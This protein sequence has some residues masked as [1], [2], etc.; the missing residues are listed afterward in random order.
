MVV[1]L[2]VIS[3]CLAV[4]WSAIGATNVLGVQLSLMKAAIDG[5]VIRDVSAGSAFAERLSFK[6]GAAATVA[7]KSPLNAISAIN[8]SIICLMESFFSFRYP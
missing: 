2:R 1:L 8:A 6:T 3:C 4:A 5:V 7:D